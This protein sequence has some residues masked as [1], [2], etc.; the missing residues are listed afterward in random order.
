M[1]LLRNLKG[2]LADAAFNMKLR[3]SSSLLSKHSQIA[4]QAQHHRVNQKFGDGKLL[5]LDQNFPTFLFHF[6]WALCIAQE[7]YLIDQ[8]LACSNLLLVIRSQAFACCQA[9]N[10]TFVSPGEREELS[11]PAFVHKKRNMYLMI[12][13]RCLLAVTASKQAENRAKRRD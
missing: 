8:S 11:K 12:H 5:Q 10:K 1:Q 9:R 3:T 4:W 13:V 7:L 6:G 2:F